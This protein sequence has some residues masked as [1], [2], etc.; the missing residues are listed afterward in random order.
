MGNQKVASTFKQS[1]INNRTSFLQRPTHSTTLN[2]EASVKK[3]PRTPFPVKSPR[4]SG[5]STRPES[6]IVIS[7]SEAAST[8]TPMSSSASRKPIDTKKSF[9]SSVGV[10]PSSSSR[11]A[12][13]AA[14]QLLFSNWTQFI[15]GGKPMNSDEHV[16]SLKRKRDGSASP[17]CSSNSQD[18]RDRPSNSREVLPNHQLTFAEQERGTSKSPRK[19][20]P[21]DTSNSMRTISHDTRRKVSRPLDSSRNSGNAT[22]SKAPLDLTDIE[23]LDVEPSHENG[24]ENHEMNR[25]LGPGEG[26]HKLDDIVS[27]ALENSKGE[28][29]QEDIGKLATA[30]DTEWEYTVWTS[31]SGEAK[32]TAGALLPRGYT[33]HDD[34]QL[35]WICPVRS[36]RILYSTLW[37]LGCHFSRMHRAWL[38]NDN[39]D[40]TLSVVQERDG[41]EFK[42]PP[43]VVSKLSLDPTEPSMAKPSLTQYY[44][45]LYGVF[46]YATPTPSPYP[47]PA[48]S[49]GYL[50]R[51]LRTK[52]QEPKSYKLTRRPVYRATPTHSAPSSQPKYISLPEAG[53]RLWRYVQSRLVNT[54]L[55]PIPQRGHVRELLQQLSRVRDI[56]FN[57]YSQNPYS[58][59]RDQDISAM[60]LQAGGKQAK[61]PCSRCKNGKGPFQ[62]CYVMPTD[63]PL[64]ERR[65]ILGCANCYYKCN[66]T[67]CDIKPWSLKTYPELSAPWHQKIA[68]ERLAAQPDSHSPAQTE[69]LP[70]RQSMR[71][72]L[73][74][75]TIPPTATRSHYSGY[76]TGHSSRLLTES[77][78]KKCKEV[79]NCSSNQLSSPN[80]NARTSSKHALS[81]VQTP[82]PGGHA[83][84]ANPAHMLQLETWEVAPGRIRDEKSDIIDNFAF[85]NTY[86]A[87]N[88]VVR[89]SRD[90]SFQV[91]TIKP[92]TVHSWEAS[93]DTI[94]LCSIA[95]GK[96]QVKMHGQEFPMGPNGMIRIKSG[97]G[98]TVMNRLY[99]DAMV[100]VSVLPGDLC[101]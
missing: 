18:S 34:P 42:M 10:G 36:C 87:Q 79:I 84:A 35:P 83:I 13:G 90:I 70:E 28:G 61:V 74:E 76:R 19:L 92:G 56:Q 23:M 20:S 63:A 6:A 100:H 33:L 15:R 95:S 22:P 32:R 38:F 101:G 41:A 44:Q 97:V 16:K 25:L 89:I 5:P 24:S 7:D 49:P 29:L 71:I 21:K 8:V 81:G 50:R 39:G 17:V 58:E 59:A 48:S 66:Q 45:D 78:Q 31:P 94:R 62:G 43:T 88:Q 47:S 85:S 2:L 40:G 91:I 4:A 65:A 69:K 75:P 77:A 30:T 98:C 11:T 96:L 1:T 37:G 93:S 26:D 82:S 64:S 3:S 72:V 51:S 86:L 12:L 9:G 60:I 14:R 80:S 53:M 67:N 73:K 68:T 57:A 55:S 27:T 52:A 46:K 54:P 99:V